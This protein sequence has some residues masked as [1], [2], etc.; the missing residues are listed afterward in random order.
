MKCTYVHGE[1]EGEDVLSYEDWQVKVKCNYF[2][3]KHQE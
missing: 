3:S 2:H 1:I